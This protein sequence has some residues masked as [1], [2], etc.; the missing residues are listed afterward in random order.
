MSAHT[1]KRLPAAL[2][3]LLLL[4]LGSVARAG[5]PSKPIDRSGGPPDSEPTMVGDPDAGHNGLWSYV[6]Q[7]LIVAQLN[8]SFLPTYTPP[9]PATTRHLRRPSSLRVRRR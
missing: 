9:I 6:R 8:S 4:T 7:I 1:R 3:V 2:C 5:M